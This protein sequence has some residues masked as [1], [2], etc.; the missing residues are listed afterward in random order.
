MSFVFF[1]L[2]F[3]FFLVEIIEQSGSLPKKSDRTNEKYHLLTLYQAFVFF[4]MYVNAVV[5]DSAKIDNLDNQ[6]GKLVT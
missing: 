1:F 3:F 5:P 4:E 6:S 2:F